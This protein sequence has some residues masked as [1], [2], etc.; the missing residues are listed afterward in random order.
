MKN[1]YDLNPKKK[2][3]NFQIKNYMFY[4]IFEGNGEYTQKHKENDYRI[5]IERNYESKSNQN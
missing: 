5:Y 4:W 2:I 1:L 3:E